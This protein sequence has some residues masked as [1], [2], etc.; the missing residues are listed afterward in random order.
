MRGWFGRWGP[1]GL[2]HL[3]G[4]LVSGRRG[5]SS[6]GHLLPPGEKAAA[7]AEAASGDEEADATEAAAAAAVAV[8]AAK[9]RAAGAVDPLAMLE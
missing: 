3:G 8:E 7:D 5:S 1:L 4:W 9:A 2:R 6:P